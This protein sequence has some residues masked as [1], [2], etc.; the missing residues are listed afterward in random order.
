MRRRGRTYI[1]GAASAAGV[2]AF[3]I[4][5]AAGVAASATPKLGPHLVRCKGTLTTKL[6]PADLGLPPANGTQKGVVRCKKHLG[7]GHEKTTFKTNAV[8]GDV[9][10]TFV[11][12]FKKK[13]GKVTGKFKL[14]PQEGSLGNG[15]PYAPGMFGAVNYAGTLKKVTWGKGKFV[16]VKGTGSVVESSLD[17]ITFKVVEKI[18][19]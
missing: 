6:T 4:T 5:P 3:A 13:V 16:G 7:K 17:G 18:P 15:N 8:S 9:T 14:I 1:V 11:I 10:G 19:T 12:K 2:L